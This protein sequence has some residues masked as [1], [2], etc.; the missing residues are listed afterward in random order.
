ML[1]GLFALVAVSGAQADRI[2]AVRSVVDHAYAARRANEPDRVET[3]VFAQG[4]YFNAIPM[5]RTLERM[6]FRTI[7]TT[8]AVDLQKQ[9][10]AP[11][12]SVLAA[13]LV[14]VVH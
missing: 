10:Y 9:R 2:V 7:A 6:E 11:A 12:A 4:Q 13:D 8:L 14:L 5:D 1:A 3:Y